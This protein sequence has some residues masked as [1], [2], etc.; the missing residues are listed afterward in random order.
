EALLSLAA[1]QMLGGKGQE[2]R[3]LLMDTDAALETLARAL[4]DVNRAAL[5][6]QALEH[7]PLRVGQRSPP[8]HPPPH[9]RLQ[10]APIHL[11]QQRTAQLIFLL[12]HRRLLESRDDDDCIVFL[13]AQEKNVRKNCVEC[14]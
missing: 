7:P 4:V 2:L 6:D 9:H 1:G 5:L 14:E 10:L 12:L 8:H 3:E 13:D 11:E